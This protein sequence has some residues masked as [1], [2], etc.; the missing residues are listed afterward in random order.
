MIF[1]LLPIFN[2]SEN[3]KELC[4]RIDI[5]MQ[6]HGFEYNIIAYND[7]STDATLD[8]LHLLST[9]LPIK[10]IGKMQNEGLGFAFQSLLKEV[11]QIS[12]SDDD[13]AVVLDADNSHNPELVYDMVT[14]LHYGFD[15]IIASRYLQGS[16]VVG[17][18]CFRQIMSLGASYL[19]RILFPIKGVKDYTCGY[20]AYRV[21]CLQAALNEYNNLLIEEMGFAC[22][23][24]LLIKLRAMNV[25]FDEV[26]LILRYDKKLGESKMDVKKTIIKTLF[27]LLRLKKI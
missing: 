2:E 13:I 20:R 9:S 26:P 21:S 18:T 14:R 25:L 24:E 11:C 1:I 19:M 16:R 22:M 27:M 5:S 8:I 17:V 3:L 10:I 12:V 23:A 6:R 7:G 15:V 4:S